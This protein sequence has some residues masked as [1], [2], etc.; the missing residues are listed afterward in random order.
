MKLHT[1]ESKSTPKKLI[2]NISGLMSGKEIIFFFDHNL[3]L[4]KTKITQNA[5]V[6]LQSLF[7]LIT[8]HI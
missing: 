1:N 6:A 3:P 5:R 8:L 7:Y 4:L 2:E